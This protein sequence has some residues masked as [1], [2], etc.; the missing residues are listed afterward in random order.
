MN[1][2]RAAA[3]GVVLSAALSSC[4]PLPQNTDEYRTMIAAH[5]RGRVEH[6]QI[7]DRPSEVLDRLDTAFRYCIDREDVSCYQGCTREVHVHRLEPGAEGRTTISVR[8]F[9]NG[10]APRR[11]P[12]DGMIEWMVDVEESGQGAE[13]TWYGGDHQLFVPYLDAVRRWSQAIEHP[14]ACPDVSRPGFR[15]L[16][17][18]TPESTP[19]ASTPP[20]NATETTTPPQNTRSARRR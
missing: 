1:P 15:D 16:R 13:I 10:R 20:A 2:I 4:T 8:S 9:V 5:R 11:A 7:A 6:W 19:D 3:I 12:A 14:V 17:R 18:A